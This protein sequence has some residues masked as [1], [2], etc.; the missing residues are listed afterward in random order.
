MVYS[1]GRQPRAVSNIACLDEFEYIDSRNKTTKKGKIKKTIGFKRLIIWRS[2]MKARELTKDEVISK[3]REHRDDLDKFGVKRI[4]LF[5]S[6]A[7]G[8]QKAKSDI[9]LVVEF[10]PSCFGPNFKGLFDEYMRLSRFLESLFKRK[11]DI[12]TPISIE[13]IRVKQV[14]EDI[15]GSIIYA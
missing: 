5:G 11:V 10:D 9:D 15:K 13:T 3:L 12:L 1:V 14:A 6:F 8:G 2:G 7:K 4:G